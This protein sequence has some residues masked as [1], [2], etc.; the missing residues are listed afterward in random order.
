[1]PRI[2][3]SGVKVN[4][5]TLTF[6]SPRLILVGGMKRKTDDKRRKGGE[7]ELSLSEDQQA[8]VDAAD[9]FATQRLKPGYRAREHAG[10]IERELAR[11]MGQL[12]FIAPELPV[13]FG[14]SG[15]DRLSSG[16]LL[17]SIARGDFN[18]AYVNLLASLCGQ[19]V[20]QYV[21][22][23]LHGKGMV[24]G[25]D[26]GRETHRD[27]PDRTPRR[28][29]RRP[30]PVASAAQRRSFRAQRREGLDFDGYPSRRGGS[31]Y[32]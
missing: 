20:A 4:V 13:D 25:S 23:L 16:L 19:I 12:G 15:L 27:R 11:E 7:M 5:L 8:L 30:H 10:R 28:V 29:G 9:R 14:G 24:A 32:G 31:P 3:F 17:E 18:V 22:P 6:P 21:R 2:K 1:M 26:G